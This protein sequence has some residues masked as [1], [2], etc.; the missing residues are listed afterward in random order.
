MLVEVIGLQL[1]GDGALDSLPALV[2]T[3]TISRTS[4]RLTHCL[5]PK[6]SKALFKKT[7][8]RTTLLHKIKFVWLRISRSAVILIKM[9][10]GFSHSFLKKVKIVTESGYG[11]FLQNLLPFSFTGQTSLDLISHWPWTILQYKMYINRQIKNLERF[12]V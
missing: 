3:A 1:A 2:A 4:I 7:P 6:Y 10:R 8:T 5:I 9:L 12:L 11:L